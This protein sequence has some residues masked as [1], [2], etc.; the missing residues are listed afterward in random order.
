MVGTPELWSE[1][2][3]I[4]SECFPVDSIPPIDLEETWDVCCEKVPSYLNGRPWTDVWDELINTDLSPGIGTYAVYTSEDVLNYYLPVIILTLF[5]GNY[6]DS[7]MAG[8]ALK[9]GGR[10]YSTL[11]DDY[12]RGAV[13]QCVDVF[14]R[15]FVGDNSLN[16]LFGDYSELVLSWCKFHD[17]CPL[18]NSRAPS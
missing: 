2:K 3:G 7:T 16:G 14:F 1:L 10:A 8:V 17:R 4:C 13:E 11:L 5:L 18:C 12:Q 6:T 15:T 9:K